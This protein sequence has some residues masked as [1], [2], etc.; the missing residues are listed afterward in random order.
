MQVAPSLHDLD[1]IYDAPLKL[2]GLLLMVEVVNRLFK[3][4]RGEG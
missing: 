1:D 3:D 4:Y 2:F